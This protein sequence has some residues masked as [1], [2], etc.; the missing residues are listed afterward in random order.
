MAPH[1]TV[2]F[3]CVKTLQMYSTACREAITDATWICA[4]SPLLSKALYASYMLAPAASI[5]SAI[6]SVLPSMSGEARYSN[7]T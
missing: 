6:I 1:H 5:G 2:V 4:G 7:S 3:S